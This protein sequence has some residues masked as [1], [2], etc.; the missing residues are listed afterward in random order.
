M[1]FALS[2]Y[3]I[4]WLICLEVFDLSS[5][6]NEER[7]CQKKT[8]WFENNS[9]AWFNRTKIYSNTRGGEIKQ[10]SPGRFFLSVNSGVGRYQW[11]C[12]TWPQG[13]TFLLL[14]YLNISCPCLSWSAWVPIV[15]RNS[16]CTDGYNLRLHVEKFPIMGSGA[17]KAE[18]KHFL[19]LQGYKGGE[20]L[21]G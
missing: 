4:S 19:L 2:E 7:E 12:K 8:L 13:M 17:C 3:K 15:G 11:Y 16:T 9:Q 6:E 18:G 14:T 1:K 20:C 21:G 10:T 5:L